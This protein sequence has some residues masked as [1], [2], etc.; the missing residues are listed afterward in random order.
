[1]SYDLMSKTIC[2]GCTITIEQRNGVIYHKYTSRR[3]TGT[4]ALQSFSDRPYQR[5][6][7]LPTGFDV[8]RK[9]YKEVKWVAEPSISNIPE[10]IREFQNDRLFHFDFSKEDISRKKK[11]FEHQIQVFKDYSVVFGIICYDFKLNVG[12]QYAFSTSQDSTKFAYALGLTETV[13]LDEEGTERCRV[14][15][16][17]FEDAG[18]NALDLLKLHVMVY[19]N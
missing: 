13:L 6:T 1:M 2:G 8:V 3:R 10:I 18:D 17:E 12:R 11:A 4:L 7:F 15:I 9:L 19:C 5:L 14:P 16:K